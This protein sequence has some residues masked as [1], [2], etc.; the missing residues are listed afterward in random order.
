M[1]FYRTSFYFYM[2]KNNNLQSQISQITI[3]YLLSYFC[4]SF[5]SVKTTCNANDK[6]KHHQ[7]AFEHL[8]KAA[9]A[10]QTISIGV[11]EYMILASVCCLSC[12]DLTDELF[13]AMMCVCLIIE[14][15]EYSKTEKSNRLLAPQPEI[16]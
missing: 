6:Y 3:T 14:I 4:M 16:I 1:L 7:F 11:C 12:S 8:Q 13:S 5:Y 10:I 9:D 2:N 15:E